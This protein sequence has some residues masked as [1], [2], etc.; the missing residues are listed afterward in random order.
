MRLRMSKADI[1]RAHAIRQKMRDEAIMLKT[2]VP[3]V[4]DTLVLSALELEACINVIVSLQ[5]QLDNPLVAAVLKG[6][7]SRFELGDYSDMCGPGW[8][9]EEVHSREEG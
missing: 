3:P 4:H 6:D 7:V 2:L 9:V 1:D 8:W 5:E